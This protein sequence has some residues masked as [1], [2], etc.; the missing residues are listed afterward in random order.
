[1]VIKL[2]LQCNGIDEIDEVHVADATIHI[3][4]ITENKVLKTQEWNIPTLII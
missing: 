2:E 4:N 3:E 1:M